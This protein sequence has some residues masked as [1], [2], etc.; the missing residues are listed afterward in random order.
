MNEAIRILCADHLHQCMWLSATPEH[1]RLRI[2]YATTSNFADSTLPVILYCGPMFGSRYGCLDINRLANEIGVR[3][4][5][6]DRPGM[7]GS[8]LCPLNI[9]IKVWLE[10]VPALL[11]KLNVK[12]VSLVSHSAGTMY[13]LNTMYYLRDI[14]DPNAPYVALAGPF[15][16]KEHTHATLPSLGSRLP[17]S[18]L[19]SWSSVNRFI[20]SRVMPATSWSGGLITS[21][22]ELFQSEPG[23]SN[24][25]EMTFA[26]KLGVSEEVGNAAEK[27]Q[28][29]YFLAE[30]TEAATQ[31]LL[32]CLN[33]GEA[34]SWGIC[35]DYSAYVNQ[36]VQSERE[37]WES[38]QKASPAKLRLKFFF[39]ESDVMIGE[40]GRRYVEEC[41]KQT[42]VGD[43]MDV[44]T[45]VLKVTES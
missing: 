13:L 31:E 44:T 3:I 9:R 36:L 15:A 32:L 39:A 25:G 11:K 45:T 40:G 5:C 12:H 1:E 37:R 19:H 33:K 28:I 38:T 2:T 22:A 43:V 27:L 8:T 35:E 18:W 17:I 10:T 30:N 7:G 24:S 42:G 16:N 6:V 41:W 21:T 14:L 29:K 23:T 4:I 26:E 34:G 20:L